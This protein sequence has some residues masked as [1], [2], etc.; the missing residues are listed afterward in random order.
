MAGLSSLNLAGH[1]D[2]PSTRHLLPRCG[3]IT[4][5]YQGLGIPAEIRTLVSALKG[6]RPR[7]L[8]DRDIF[9]YADLALPAASV[10]RILA[11]MS[12]L[13]ARAGALRAVGRATGV[14]SET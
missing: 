11:W 2:I 13:G 6:Q 14:G 1:G 12:V 7:P 9:D 10:A 3:A 4:S 5:D 8:D